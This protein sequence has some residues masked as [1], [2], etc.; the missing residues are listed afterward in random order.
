[1][2]R[3]PLTARRRRNVVVAVLTIGLLTSALVAFTIYYMDQ[4]QPHI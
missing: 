1:M 3:D 2:N 4:I